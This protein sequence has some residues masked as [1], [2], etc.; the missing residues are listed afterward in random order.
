MN[1]PMILL[2]ATG[3]RVRVRGMVFSASYEITHELLTHEMSYTARL[4]PS[5]IHTE[6]CMAHQPFFS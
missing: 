4:Q 6:V 2:G 1:F 5:P 3:H